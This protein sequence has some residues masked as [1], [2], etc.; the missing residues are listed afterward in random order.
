VALLYPIT[1]GLRLTLASS[2]ISQRAS[3]FVFLGVAFLAGLLTVRSTRVAWRPRALLAARLALTATAVMSLIGSVLLGELSATRQPGP[4]LV[5][6]EDRSVTPEGVAAAAFASAHLQAR[7]RALVDRTNATLLGSYGNLNPIFGRYGGTPL[8]RILLGSRF[9]ATDLLALR[10]QSLAYIVVDRRLAR[11][12]PLIGYY[13]ESDE[14]G[15]FVRRLPVSVSALSKFT[16]VA[17]VSK[18][19]SDGPIDIYDTRELLR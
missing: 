17:G 13:V 16:P 7:S 12:P 15:A 10:G 4:Y 3:G 8:P 9:D 18:V 5:G 2:E 14:P 6:A 1:L 19:Y 11:E